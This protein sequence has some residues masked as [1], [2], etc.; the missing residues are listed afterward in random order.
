MTNAARTRESSLFC[1]LRTLR[2]RLYVVVVVTLLSP[3]AIVGCSR[4]LSGGR[5]LAMARWVQTR[6]TILQDLAANAY[7]TGALETAQGK[8]M[9]VLERDP[10]NESVKLLLAHVLLENGQPEQSAILL[11]ELE[12]NGR[13]NPQVYYLAGLTKELRRDYSAAARY[14]ARAL[15][16][17]PGHQPYVRATAEALLASGNVSGAKAFLGT[18]DSPLKDSPDWL[19]LQAEAACLDQRYEPAAALYREALEVSSVAGD[20]D[21][22]IMRRLAG[23]YQKLDRHADAVELLESLSRNT[24]DADPIGIGE[25]LAWCYL[26]LKRTQDAAETIS[27]L[28]AEDRDVSALWTALAQLHLEQENWARAKQAL[29]RAFI[30]DPSDAN[31]LMLSTFISIR[32]GDTTAAHKTF[33]R[34]RVIP[35]KTAMLR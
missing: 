34:W 31:S 17:R 28:K 22:R 4:P 30:A 33:A 6:N 8:L 9:D 32:A 27:A 11:Q 16:E 26:K 21:Q 3:M 1:N 14:Y 2:K 29:G 23:V 13:A 12:A 5:E 15:R 25:E 10:N 7:Q 24:H 20:G 35:P 19:C 18:I